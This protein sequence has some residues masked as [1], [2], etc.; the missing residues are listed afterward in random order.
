MMTVRCNDVENP[1]VKGDYY[2]SERIYDICDRCGG[3]I[4]EGETFY[5]IDGAPVCGECMQ[6]A[7][8]TA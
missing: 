2:E 6:K 3:P 5:L 8:R 7:R 4:Y 1:I